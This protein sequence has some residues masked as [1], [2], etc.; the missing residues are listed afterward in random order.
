MHS[1]VKGFAPLS[2]RLNSINFIIDADNSH[3]EVELSSLLSQKVEELM[4]SEMG[5]LGRYIV[6]NQCN[7]AGIDPEK[8]NKGDLPRLSRLLS[9]TMATFGPDKARRVSD[10]MG[11]LAN[12]EAI[13]DGEKEPA[14]QMEGYYS[15]GELSRLC[16]DFE[17]STLYFERLLEMSVE[18]GDQHMRALAH[19]GIG[20]VRSDMSDNFLALDSFERGLAIAEKLEDG[21][22]M[23]RL[24]YGI[25]R[26]H[27]RRG[28]YEKAKRHYTKSLEMASGDAGLVSQLKMDMGLVHDALGD[29]PMALLSIQEAIDTAPAAQLYDVARLY[30][31]LGEVQRHMGNWEEA[32]KK[33]AVSIEK[34]RELKNERVMAYA[35]ANSADCYMKIRGDEKAKELLEGALDIALKAR[36]DFLIG[37]VYQTLGAMYARERNLVKMEES[38]DRAE[39]TFR[40]IQSPYDLGMTMLEHGRALKGMRKRAEA[41]VSLARA[42]V[43]FKDLKSVKFCQQTERELEGL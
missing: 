34:G 16:S 13:V 10:G 15:L 5:E 36:D 27:L 14:K 32:I 29:Y 41:K 42:L 30:N 17:K 39:K 23:A 40:R 25:G 37:T 18:A 28:D 43:I 19:Y 6:R 9:E 4:E 1:S 3:R 26:C 20:M 35:M 38:Y 12:L 22:L 7:K 2:L 8:I 31:N 21:L 24:F 33:Y 11:K